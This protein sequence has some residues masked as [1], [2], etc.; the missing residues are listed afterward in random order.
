MSE[1]EKEECRS[2]LE[3]ELHTLRSNLDTMNINVARLRKLVRD[4]KKE[5]KKLYNQL[6]KLVYE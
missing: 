1:K 6:M 2:K 3:H 5:I 4:K